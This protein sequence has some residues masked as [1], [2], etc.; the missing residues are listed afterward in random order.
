MLWKVFSS[1]LVTIPA[2]TP[3]H[4]TLTNEKKM[5]PDSDKW[6]NNVLTFPHISPTTT[7]R[8]VDLKIVYSCCFR[9][10]LTGLMFRRHLSGLGKHAHLWSD[11]PVSQNSIENRITNL[12]VKIQYITD[13]YNGLQIDLKVIPSTGGN[14]QPTWVPSHHFS[15]HLIN[16]TLL[17]LKILW[18]YPNTIKSEFFPVSEQNAANIEKVSQQREKSSL[19]REKKCLSRERKNNE[20]STSS[21]LNCPHASLKT[22]Q[23]IIEEWQSSCDIQREDATMKCS[24]KNIPSEQPL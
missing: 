3:W 24:S 2:V 10:Q 23:V 18:Y 6:E 11:P 20:K 15:C 21:V 19:R 14:D 16:K 8:V 1:L 13:H 9:K 22:T 7:A 5:A 4:Q 17:W 12:L